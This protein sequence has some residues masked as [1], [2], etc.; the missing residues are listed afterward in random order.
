MGGLMGLNRDE[1]IQNTHFR[2]LFIKGLYRSV[3]RDELQK[4]CEKFGFIETLTL[5][6]KIVDKQV[7]SR[8]LAIVQF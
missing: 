1:L 3:T 6:T 8:G 7:V 2:V 4:V 5:K